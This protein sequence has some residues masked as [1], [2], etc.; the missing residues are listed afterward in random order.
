MYS[1]HHLALL[2]LRPKNSQAQKVLT[3]HGSIV[4]RDGFHGSVLDIG[5]FRSQSGQHV[6]A[7]IGR[8]RATDIRINLSFISRLQCWFSIDHG[9]RQIALHDGSNTRTTKFIDDKGTDLL[10]TP[11][12]KL[13]LSGRENGTILIGNR[14]NCVMFELVWLKTA[15]QIPPWIRNRR[16]ASP[17]RGFINSPHAETV[18]ENNLAIVPPSRRSDS[19]VHTKWGVIGSGSFGEVFKAMGKNGE[20][21]AVKVCEVPGER[22]FKMLR[23]EVDILSRLNHPH[24]VNFIG[25]QG[26]EE[27]KRIEIFM[28]IKRGSLDSLLAH[29]AVPPKLVGDLPNDIPF[30]SIFLKQ[31]L[32]ALDYL[33][34]KH[35]IHRDIKPENILYE[36]ERDQFT[37]QL[38][39]FGTSHN[40][41]GEPKT[42]SGTGIYMPPEMGIDSQTSKVDVWSLF[43]VLVWILDIDD[44]RWKADTDSFES[45][46]AR[47]SITEQAIKSGLGKY[48]HM[49]K[50]RVEDRASAAQML[51]KHYGGEGASTYFIT[52]LTDA[53]APH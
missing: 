25:S 33:A 20:I 4:G 44:F 28:G 23:N 43:M 47:I 38:A 18:Q 36:G 13:I 34:I 26:W 16:N 39:D 37:F 50:L 41:H 17:G 15:E 45:R 5:H 6:L 27:G 51:L 29:D 12:R 21:M 42:L 52:P 19:I 9:S 10:S 35:V 1:H 8:S 49:V 53:G 24:I 2:S 22:Y 30:I 3:D 14:H 40:G 31:M 46:D 7:S 48:W 11:Q 32:Q